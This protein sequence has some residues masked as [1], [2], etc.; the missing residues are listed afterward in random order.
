MQIHELNQLS[1]DPQS[2]DTLVLDTGEQTVKIDYN[3][4]ADAI[5]AKFAPLAVNKGGTGATDAEGARTNLGAV[6]KAGDTM[7]GALYFVS[8]GGFGVDIKTTA[9]GAR[10]LSMRFVENSGAER[11]YFYQFKADNT[12]YDLFRMPTT[13]TS[14]TSNGTY[15]ILSSKSPVTVEHGGTG[16]NNASGALKNLGYANTSYDQTS[17]T[18]VGALSQNGVW[19]VAVHDSAD[20][21]NYW[22][23]IINKVSGAN[24][25][26][27]T[28]ANNNIGAPWGNTIGT[29]VFSGASGNY[30]AK[31]V[32]IL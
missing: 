17:G 14:E 23:G 29:I 11:T 4:L 12:H 7:T 5:I 8:N 30:V 18:L 16:A 24:P 3:A 9:S 31:C 20:F 10:G 28:I 32:R 27:T 2:G 19:L 22:T 1:R 6:N 25:V 15:D 26:P 21:A 13:N